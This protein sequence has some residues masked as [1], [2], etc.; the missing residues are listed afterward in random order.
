MSIKL[1]HV[2]DIHF[3]SGESHGSI[4]AETGLNVRFEDFA[5]AFAQVVDYAIEKQAD[6]F[7]F[8]GDAYKTASPEPVHQQAFA[9]QLK[10]LSDAKIP[11]V[12]LVGNHDQILKG[13]SSHSMSVFQSLEVPRIQII[14]TPQL[15]KIKTKK[16]KLQIIGIPHITRHFMMTQSKYADLSAAEIDR[17]LVRLAADILKG[18]YEELDRKEPA[19]ATAHMM[20]DTARAGA[21]QELMVGYSMTFPLSL[22]LDERLDYVALGHVHGHQ[23]L[24][25]EKPLIAYA[26]SLERVDFSEEKEDKGFIEADIERGAVRLKF[27]S[28]N[29]RPFITVDVDLSNSENPSEDLLARVLPS[30]RKGAVFRI[31]YRI[32]QDRLSE[33][34]E[35][36]VRAALPE[37]LSLR[38][39]PEL[40]LT[41]RPRRMSGISEKSVL[42]PLTALE[43]YLNEKA[44]E[45]KESLMKRAQ[46]LVAQ[47]EQEDLN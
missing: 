19:V 6:V 1:I 17:S 27:H 3:G 24:R 41:Q 26:G 16:G 46:F 7:L 34:D 39:K 18:F 21:E 42:Q 23:I 2:S 9:A 25:A 11:T 33:L 36:K 13:G 15:L 14:Q 37:L 28:I 10:R 29:P 43:T 47:Q 20:M 4:N 45:R 22:F 30:V 35:N 40:L 44:P 8:S 32:Q 31:K 38:F 5:R 12:L